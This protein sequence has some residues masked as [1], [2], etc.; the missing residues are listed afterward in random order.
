MDFKIVFIDDNLSET[1]PFVQNIRKSY[2]SVDCTQVFKDPNQGLGYVLNNL[3]ERM[4][5]FIDWSFGANKSTG[6]D[7]LR[8]IRKKTSLLYVVMMSVNQLANH[9][10]PSESIIEMMN[11]DNIFYLDRSNSNFEV[12]RSIID[13]IQ[14]DWETKFDCILEQWLIRH[15][16]DNKKEAFSDITS[17]RVYTWEEILL[18]LRRQSNVGKSFEGKLNEY[19][20]HLLK[21][22]KR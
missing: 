11:E 22:A 18:E 13:R 5:V 4:I 15:P 19:Y 17:G 8:E 12:V 1:E 6:I 20:I 16:E 21:R 10:F 14:R 3:N 9:N 7:L 2:K